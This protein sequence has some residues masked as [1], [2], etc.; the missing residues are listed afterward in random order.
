MKKSRTEYNREWRKRNPEKC[1]ISSQK[2]RAKNRDKINKQTKKY[3][4]AHPEEFRQKQLRRKLKIYGITP[5]IY[6]DIFEKQNGVC[7]I[8][9]NIQDRKNRKMLAVDHCHNTGK[10]RGLL[11]DKCN[12][13]LGHFDNVKDLELAINYL[14][15]FDPYK[16]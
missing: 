16:D 13:G 9:G 8:C 3:W 10:V 11:C 7:A 15:T 4:D 6:N 1:K 2:Y 5:Q 14:Q 12:I